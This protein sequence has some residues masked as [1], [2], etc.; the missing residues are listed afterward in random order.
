M[1]ML[2]VLFTSLCTP[3]GFAHVFTVLGQIIV[4]PEVHVHTLDFVTFVMLFAG[5]KSV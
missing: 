2:G 3:V 1:S 5:Y 4:Q